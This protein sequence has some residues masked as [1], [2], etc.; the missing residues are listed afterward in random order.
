MTETTVASSLSDLAAPPTQFTA[1]N[2]DND[3]ICEKLLLLQE[4]KYEWPTNTAH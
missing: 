3:V 1:T 4:Q 2:A